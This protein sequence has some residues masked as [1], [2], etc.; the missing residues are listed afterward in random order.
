VP[1]LFQKSGYWGD[2]DNYIQFINFSSKWDV[3]VCWIDEEGGVVPRVTLKANSAQSRHMELTSTR[4]VWCLIATLTT[5]PDVN[6]PKEEEEVHADGDEESTGPK[7]IPNNSP[8]IMLLRCSKASLQP[9]KYASMI[10]SPWQSV[11]A[12]QRVRPKPLP[13][14]CALCVFFAYCVCPVPHIPLKFGRKDHILGDNGESN[15]VTP[16]CLARQA[17][18]WPGAFPPVTPNTHSAQTAHETSKCAAA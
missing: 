6:A 7:V 1:Q 4:H 18:T 3:Q 11:S 2:P 9:R 5:N 17:L 16:L 10:W 15:G 13:G 8:V 12:T 14:M